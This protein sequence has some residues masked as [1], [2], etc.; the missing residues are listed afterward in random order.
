MD[1]GRKKVCIITATRAE[2]G[3]LKPLVVALQKMPELE[4]QLVVTGSHLLESQGYTYKEIEKDGIGIF[5]KIPI[6]ITENTNYGIT[7]SMEIGRAHV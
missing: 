7:L 2:Y 1:L 6:N 3:L 4:T 5:A